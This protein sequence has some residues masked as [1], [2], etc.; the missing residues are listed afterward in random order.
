MTAPRMIGKSPESFQ[1][2]AQ[3]G[4]GPPN[5]WREGKTMKKGIL[6]LAALAAL[7]FVAGPASADKSNGEKGLCNAYDRGGE[8]GQAMKRLHGQ[9]FV[10]LTAAACSATG[11]VCEEGCECDT[12]DDPSTMEDERTDCANDPVDCT[13]QYCE[14]KA[15]G[16]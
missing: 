13:H 14:G 1:T 8:Q 2:A 16:R 10:R 3:E 9:A 6:L 15:A 12:E 7:L 4:A 5:L 11:V